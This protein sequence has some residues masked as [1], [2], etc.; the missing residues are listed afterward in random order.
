MKKIIIITFLIFLIFNCAGQ[1]KVESIARYDDGQK[2]EVE[3]DKDGKEDGRR[4]FYYEN[5]QICEEGN[6]KNGKEDGKWTIY[7]EDGQ[8]KEVGN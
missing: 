3:N 1:V 2:N 8:K 4:T 5:G 7:F 6:F